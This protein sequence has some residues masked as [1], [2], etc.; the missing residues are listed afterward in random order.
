MIKRK[1]QKVY[2]WDVTFPLLIN[3]MVLNE[4]RKNVSLETAIGPTVPR[5]VFWWKGSDK[6]ST[7]RYTVNNG[8]FIFGVYT[9]F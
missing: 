5:S 2:F 7:F 1:R 6:P 9:T 3:E 4:R 8:N